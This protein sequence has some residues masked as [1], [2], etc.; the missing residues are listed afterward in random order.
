MTS[1]IPYRALFLGAGP[2]M[3]CGVGQFTIRLHDAVESLTPG[4]CASLTLTAGEGSLPA[5]WRAVGSADTVVCNFPIVAWKR[6]ILKPLLAMAMARLRR[7]RVLLIQH[8]WGSLHRLRRLTYLPALWLAD[9]IMM[10]SPLVRRELAD[11]PIAGRFNRKCV[12]APLPPVTAT[13][14][15]TTD[16]ELRRRLAAATRDGR[17]VLG[18]FGS[19]YP[20]KQPQVLLD[21]ASILKRR[22]LRPLT[23][24][25]GSFIRALDGVEQ[26]FNRRLEQLGLT[27]DVI[28]TGYVESEQDVFG[29]FGEIDVFCYIL[30]EGLTARRTSILTVAQSQRPVVVTAASEAGEFDHHPRFRDLIESGAILC[31]PRG[32]SNEQYADSI[33]A[34]RSRPPSNRPFDFNGW[35][36]DLAQAVHRQLRVPPE[37]GRQS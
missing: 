34:A 36:L 6:V 4:S 2:Q 33:V 28:V 12:L 24:Y 17:L 20:G 22:G 32:V 7:R 29:L 23:V 30:D 37:S 18:H 27:D 3:Q 16:S 10:F 14:P 21:I 8:E 19:I 5:I 25:V 11:D 15:T 1:K 13:P 31:V 9:T 35:W 26:D